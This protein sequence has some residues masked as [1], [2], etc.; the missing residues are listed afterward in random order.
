M[1]SKR[2]ARTFGQSKEFVGSCP[3]GMPL[4]D[5]K[6]TRKKLTN[7]CKG[8]KIEHKAKY[9]GFSRRIKGAY[10]QD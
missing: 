1:D 10:E 8:V 4:L 9:S 6:C 3:C 7:K 5:G 2:N